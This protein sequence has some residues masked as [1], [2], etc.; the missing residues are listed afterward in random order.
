MKDFNQASKTLGKWEEKVPSVGHFDFHLKLG[1]LS[2]EGKINFLT[3]SFSL[4][5]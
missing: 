3:V 4:F 5:N 2:E 1:D